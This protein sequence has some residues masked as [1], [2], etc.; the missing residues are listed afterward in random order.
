M[1]RRLD[2]TVSF[3]RAFDF[4]QVF[5]DAWYDL[6]NP[7]QTRIPMV[8]HF[9]TRRSDSPPNLSHLAIQHVMLY[10]VRKDGE[11][12]EQPIRS[13]RFTLAGTNGAVGGPAATVH[14]RVSTRSGNGTNWLPLIGQ[15][16]TGTWELAFSGEP[17]DRSARDRFAN[18]LIENMVLLLTVSGQRPLFSGLH[19]GCCDTRALT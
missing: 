18:E 11:V 2:Q 15:P 9:D 14:G 1:I 8:V 7:D 6:N 5:A 4:W 16:P 13:L 3:D 17:P 12:F 19:R 10:L